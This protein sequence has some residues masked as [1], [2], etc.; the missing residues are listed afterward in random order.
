MFPA[1]QLR[2]AELPLFKRKSEYKIPQKIATFF[3]LV[4]NQKKI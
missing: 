1:D 3:F 2:N 4:E